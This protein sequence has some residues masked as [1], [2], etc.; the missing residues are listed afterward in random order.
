MQQPFRHAESSSINSVLELQIDRRIRA[1]VTS[2]QH[3]GMK[4]SVPWRAHRSP[5]PCTDSDPHVARA[6]LLDSSARDAM[7]LW[8]RADEAS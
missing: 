8:K 3:Y 6:N 2:T 7:S 1:K 4:G 5:R